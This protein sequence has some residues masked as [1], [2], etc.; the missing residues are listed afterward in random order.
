[1]HVPVWRSCSQL[2]EVGRKP[3]AVHTEADKEEVK[4]EEWRGGEGIRNGDVV[5]KKGG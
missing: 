2:P 5:R 3:H 4:A 1:M